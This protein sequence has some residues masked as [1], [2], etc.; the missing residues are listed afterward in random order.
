MVQ[1]EFLLNGKG[2]YL[3]ENNNSNDFLLKF[4]EFMKDDLSD[5]FK[6]KNS[7]KKRNKKIFLFYIT[8]THL[9]KY[10]LTNN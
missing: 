2:G 5:K 3:F 1:K 7:C 10:C 9:L 4:N 8:S 6:K